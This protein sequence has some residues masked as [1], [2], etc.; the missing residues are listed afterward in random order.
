MT[1]AAELIARISAGIA[2]QQELLTSVGAIYKFALEGD[3]GGTYVLD[4]KD[5]L[6]VTE[7]DGPAGCTI[8]MSAADFVEASSRSR[9]TWG[10]PSSSSS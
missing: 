9:G 5:T 7:G 6:T 3:G 4:L 8:R 1:T 10:S 2:T